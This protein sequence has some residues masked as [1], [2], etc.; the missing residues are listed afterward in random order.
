MDGPGDY[1]TKWN[2][3][4]RERQISYNITSMWNLKK[5][6]THESI[7]KTNRL[8]DIGSKFRVVEGRGMGEGTNS[9]YGISRCKQLY[10][11]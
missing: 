8:I 10:I 9:E 2:K 11:R 4:D 5:N 1:H 6:N 7:Y 3:S